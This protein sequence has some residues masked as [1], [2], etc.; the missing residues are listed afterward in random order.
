MFR[1]KIRA[2]TRDAT[3]TYRMGAGFAGDVNRTHPASIEPVLL[4]QTVGA[5]PTGY[6]I[7]VLYSANNLGVRMINPAT[8][9]AITRIDGI[10]VRPY[11]FQQATATGVYAS[12]PFSSGANANFGGVIPYVGDI[13]KSGYIMVFVVGTPAKGAPVFI[14]VA[15]ASG[16]HVVGGW[17]AV[18]SGA[19]T[20]QLDGKSYFNG[21]PDAN[22]ITELVYNA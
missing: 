7:P 1:L 17:E 10:L 21:P 12:V 22:G 5:T 15:A 4:D 14:W 9:A 13:L 20:I 3:F 8:D 6:G 19:N 18:A 2:K 11:P 16:N